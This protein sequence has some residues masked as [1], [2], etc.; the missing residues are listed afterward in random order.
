MS[1]LTGS[2]VAFLATDGFE[3]SE[4]TEPWKAI[5]EAG[6]VPVLVSLESGTIKGYEHADPKDTFDV[7]VTVQDATNDEYDAL[8]LPGGVHNPDALRTD[9]QAVA[10]VKSFVTD[11]KPVAAI[12]HGPWLL[13]E[14]DVVKG[15]EV[16]SF[17]SIK[18][19]LKNAGA[20]W[21]DKEVVCDQGIV[22]S[23]NPSD[24]PAFCD[25]LVEEVAEG[26]HR[27][28]VAGTGAARG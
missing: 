6:G 25:K 7:D 10:F 27:R 26:H 19:D 18:T 2:K 12:C 5:K 11:G 20:N 24:L 28:Q 13:V 15:L 23:R 21:V 22:T 17:P 4:L 14:A 16:T 9:E 8:V 1:E 3:Q